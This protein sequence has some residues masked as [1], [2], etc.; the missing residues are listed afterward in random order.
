MSQVR[1]SLPLDKPLTLSSNSSLRLFKDRFAR[2]SITFGGLMVLMTLLM[3]FGYLLYVVEPVFRN[4]DVSLSHQQQLESSTDVV[5]LGSDELNEIGYYYNQQ[6]DLTFYPIL[7]T[8]P[9][10]STSALPLSANQQVSSVARGLNDVGFGLSDGSFLLSQP[11]FSLSFSDGVRSISPGVRYPLGEQS[12]EI[13]EQ[14]QAL[15]QLV[16]QRDEEQMSIVALTADNRLVY[17]LLEAQE[18]FMT[19]EVE[20]SG[21]TQQF[22]NTPAKLTKILLTPDQRLL[23]ILSENQLY[24]YDLFADEFDAPRQV[25]EIN[26]PNA[27]VTDIGLLS[28]G[29][30]ILVG[31]SNG[32][33]T[34][35]FET[36]SDRGRRM[37]RVREFSVDGAVK[38]IETEPFRKTFAVLTDKNE[39]RLFHTTS[40]AD[41]LS[42]S[43]I[44]QA[45]L[46]QFS[47]RNNA[48]M[49]QSEQS[50]DF[51]QLENEHPEVTWSA[52]WQEV[53]Y[54]GYPEADYVWQSTSA[55]DEFEPK[56]SLVPISF[57]TIKAALYAM[58]FAVPIAI[59]GAI[60][61]AYFMPAAIRRF[62][63]PTVETMEALPTVILGFLAGLWLAPIV[64]EY[65]PFIFMLI[66]LLP[67]AIVGC[68]YI[69]YLLP[70]RI[71]QLLNEEYSSLL[72]IPVIIAV[73][74]L[75]YNLS[76]VVELHMM[77]GDA[78]M[79]ISNE[80]GIDFD[81]RNALIV[82]IAMGFAVIPTIFSITE[83]AIFSVPQHLS[84]GS[85]AL[86]AT[87]WQTLIGVVLLTASPG[88]FSAVMMGLGRAV[89][90]TMIVLMATGNTPIMDWNIF[91]GMRT[92]SANIA[93]EMPESEVDSTHYRVLFLAAFVLFIFTFFFNTIAE[94]VRQRLREKYGSL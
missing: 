94:L 58:L 65:L 48:L 60:Y 39:F 83:D 68:A 8:S 79:F 40:E 91:E 13:D 81:Q 69:H 64:E 2:Y 92:L 34:Q 22:A 5:A 63:K 51:Y 44:R 66:I 9:A 90:E 30:S 25:L 1:E 17:S 49:F 14:G 93:V 24:I 29:S 6:G 21:E 54:E 80:L 52:L 41:L 88:I 73:S 23:F 18:N 86:G 12:L 59:A 89:G 57:G 67:L 45:Q 55:S 43:L 56:L 70:Q 16:Y 7:P 3:I 72:L 84:N 36:R 19:E 87:R 46:L 38:K 77:G 47:P 74:Y 37:T 15:T 10:K 32:V 53:W 33:V 20:W 76:P 4:A 31:N 42:H 26:E 82:G 11:D 50:V 27:Q 78:R 75:C 62:V 61:T 71:K 28:G 35:W 85:L